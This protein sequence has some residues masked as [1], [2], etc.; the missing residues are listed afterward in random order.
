MVK[1]LITPRPLEYDKISQDTV[2]EGVSNYDTKDVVLTNYLL[3][4]VVGLLFHS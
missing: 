3:S 4:V 2:F 1:S